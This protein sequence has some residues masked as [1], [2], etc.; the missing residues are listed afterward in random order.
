MT[1]T[2]VVFSANATAF[3]RVLMIVKGYLMV[4]DDWNM[5][6]RNPAVR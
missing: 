2:Y 5:D 3:L 1:I 6:V 4:F